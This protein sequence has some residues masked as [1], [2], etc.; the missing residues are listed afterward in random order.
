MIGRA[1]RYKSHAHLPPAQRNVT[2][3][4]LVIV[5]PPGVEGVKSADEMLRDMTKEKAT[6]NNEVIK[7]LFPLSIEQNKC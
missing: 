6:D 3:Y 1:V 2:V 5:K 7:R 4:H